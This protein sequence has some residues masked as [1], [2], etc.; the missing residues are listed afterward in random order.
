MTSYLRYKQHLAVL[1]ADDDDIETWITVKGNHIP[2]KKGQNQEDAVKNFFERKK[3]EKNIE[4]H[5]VLRKKH[6]DRYEAMKEEVLKYQKKFDEMWTSYEDYK[7][8]SEMQQLALENNLRRQILSSV[9]KMKEKEEKIIKK[10]KDIINKIENSENNLTDTG[11]AKI[12]NFGKMPLSQAK[13]AVSNLKTLQNKYP[14]MKNRL[15]FV[16]S[17]DTK[18]FKDWYKNMII[19]SSV[20]RN[21]QNIM[22][23]IHN[24]DEFVRQWDNLPEVNKQEPYYQTRYESA[25]RILAEVEKY[26]EE[27]YAKR[28]AEMHFRTTKRFA[29]R[30][31]AY[32]ICSNENRKG[33]IVFNSNNYDTHGRASG[34]FH[35]VGCDT[36]KS[37]LDHEF[38]H[39]V[40]YALELDKVFAHAEDE[41]LGKLRKFIVD[42]YRK[43]KDYIRSNLS[44]YAATDLSEFF[45]EAFAEYQN[46]PE[47]R[48]IA[49]T[50]GEYLEQYKKELEDGTDAKRREI[51]I[52]G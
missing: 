35:P 52:K 33:S 30:I 45:A 49:K 31:W 11:V 42:E 1:D 44:L 5:E 46:N 9:F 4:K 32:Y 26:G 39:S 38:G 15:E 48:H 47:P 34:D 40:Y 43:K 19:E 18:E 27:E 51:K 14:F 6:S 41:P 16:G 17:H 50:V 8:N 3:A 24:A 10:Y 22:D 13:E 20:I 2:I 23:G 12:V 36:Q 7:Q 37:V 25:K 21:Y 28:W 29:S